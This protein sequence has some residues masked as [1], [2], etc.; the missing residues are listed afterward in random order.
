MTLNGFANEFEAEAFGL[1]ASDY[2]RKLIAQKLGTR[3][4]VDRLI[5]SGKSKDMNAAKSILHYVMYPPKERGPRRVRMAPGDVIL[6]IP[7]SP[8]HMAKMQKAA[9]ARDISTKVLA[10]RILATV[11]EDNMIDAVLDDREP[12]A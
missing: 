9:D 11:S 8:A 4:I 3:S 6:E 10:H 2:C 7:V 1:T 5:A 12:A